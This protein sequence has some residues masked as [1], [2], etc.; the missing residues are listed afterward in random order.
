MC[1]EIHVP[2]L[3]KLRVAVIA[4]VA[5]LI[6]EEWKG[7]SECEEVRGAT[8]M[9]RLKNRVIE[10]KGYTYEQVQELERQNSPLVQVV[11][12]EGRPIDNA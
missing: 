8:W 5:I 9:E 6:K 3:T 11:R 1:Y 7:L 2:D 10:N 12:P 4:L